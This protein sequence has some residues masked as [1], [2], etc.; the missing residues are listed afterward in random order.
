[1]TFWVTASTRRQYIS[2]PDLVAFSISSTCDIRW[3][4]SAVA[5]LILVTHATNDRKKGW[6]GARDN[7]QA[8][9]KSLILFN[10][11]G[12]QQLCLAR[13]QLKPS[14]VF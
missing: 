7:A 13:R 1:M 4:R 14:E 8:D 9:S 5:V 12:E 11:E 2:L 6:Y 3:T 10:T